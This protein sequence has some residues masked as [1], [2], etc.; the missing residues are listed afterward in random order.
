MNKDNGGPAFPLPEGQVLHNPEHG[1]VE[2]E[3]H[4]LY[5]ESGMSLRDYFAA[6]AMQ[7]IITGNKA[8][9]CAL[10][11][12]AAHDAYAMADA[13]LTARSA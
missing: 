11:I 9:E 1:F 8:D 12:G 3:D 7:A 10:G 5:H 13:M 6:K 4:A 2:A